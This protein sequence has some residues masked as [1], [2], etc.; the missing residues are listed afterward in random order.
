[1]Q[2]ES[3]ESE[4]ILNEVEKWKQSVIPRYPDRTIK[5]MS[6]DLNGEWVFISR[7][8]NSLAPP[9]V[10][11]TSNKESL[12]T[13]VRKF[14]VL[15]LHIYIYILYCYRLFLAKI[16]LT[17]IRDPTDHRNLKT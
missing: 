13:L 8:L 6:V 14:S 3:G 15:K 7:F 2:G 4:R 1:M 10:L 9:E 11:P 17:G 12:E 16:M 5:L